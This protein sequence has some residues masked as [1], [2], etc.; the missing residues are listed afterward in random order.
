MRSK[1]IRVAITHGDTNGVGYELIYKSFAEQSMLDICTPVI[2]GNSKVA[3][4]HRT[5]LKIF[6]NLNMIANADE[7]RDE[8]INLLTATDDDVN[9][10]LGVPTVE[11]DKAAIAA[12]EMAKE[13]VDN[14]LCDVLVLSPAN[15]NNHAEVINKGE[16]TDGITILVDK[17][18]RIGL[19]SDEL[20]MENALKTI[21]KEIIVDKTK[22]FFKSLK[23]DFR[24]STPRIAVLAPGGDA[25]E[26]KQNV[27]K[28]A[29]KELEKENISAFGV[30]DSEAV[31]NDK[32]YDS[33]DGVLAICRMQGLNLSASLDATGCAELISGLNTVCT[34]VC[35]NPS[36]DTIEQGVADE[37]GL[38]NAI[39]LAIDVYRNRI[40]YD[41]PLRNPLKK[42]YRERR[43][44]SEKTRFSVPK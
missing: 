36:F 44:E 4:F 2:Y 17:F 18:I 30:F 14:K 25:D 23:R 34:S 21:T 8:R 9:V 24:V 37:S 26:D 28:E 10:E 32:L 41:F 16:N 1:K 5:K 22:A 39:Y 3:M 40:N 42:L 6:A 43:D 31:V 15:E 20:S 35:I 38:R 29:I 19:V 11:S 33:F 7:A 12:V 27:I 13:D